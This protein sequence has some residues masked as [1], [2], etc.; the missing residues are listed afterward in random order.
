MKI[1]EFMEHLARHITE[2]DIAGEPIEEIFVMVDGNEY[3]IMAVREDGYAIRVY[4]V[5]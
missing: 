5:E 1:N 3:N 4:L 2:G